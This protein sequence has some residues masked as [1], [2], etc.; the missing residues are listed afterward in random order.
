MYKITRRSVDWL[1]NVPATCYSVSQGQICT[2]SFTC[3]DT[4]IEV[5]DQTFYLT[6]SQHTDTGPTSPSADPIMPGAWQGSHWSVN[7]KSLVWL[8]PEKSRRKRDSNPESSAPEADALTQPLAQR[9]GFTKKRYWH[10]EWLWNMSI[11]LK[12]YSI[13][14]KCKYQC[15]SMLFVLAHA[16]HKISCIFTYL[17]LKCG[18]F[19][20]RGNNQVINDKLKGWMNENVKKLK[21]AGE[22]TCHKLKSTLYTGHRL[23]ST[24]YIGHRLKSTLYIAH[25]LKST[26][27]IGHKLKS[28]LYISYN[29][30][31]GILYTG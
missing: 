1:L 23:K 21:H 9:D 4:E 14:C 30:L 2:D 6:Q 17:Y 25:K 31:R 3:C 11:L 16:D 29:K 27:Y 7:F 19:A 22:H 24:L 28:T 13:M 10:S 12:K 26:L 8:D 15:F 20:S 18:G 5:A